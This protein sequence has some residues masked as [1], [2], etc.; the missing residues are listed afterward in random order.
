MKVTFEIDGEDSELLN[1]LFTDAVVHCCRMKI[2]LMVKN[3]KRD[4]DDPMFEHMCDFYDE[5]IEFYENMAK[6]IKFE[7]E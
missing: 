2:D 3:S 1:N 4:T 5:K 6:T 7:K